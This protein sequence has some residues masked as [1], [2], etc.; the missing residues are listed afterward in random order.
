MRLKAANAQVIDLGITIDVHQHDRFLYQWAQNTPHKL[1][2]IFTEEG[3][4]IKEQY[5]YAKEEVPSELMTMRDINGKPESVPVD[6][7]AKYNRE[8][9][10]YYVY[11]AY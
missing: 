10:R 7:A 1:Q 11:R 6:L 2:Q 4:A 8:D 5:T 3:E 9:K